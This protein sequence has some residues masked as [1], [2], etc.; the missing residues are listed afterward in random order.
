MPVVAS[1]QLLASA[2]KRESFVPVA[3]EHILNLPLEALTVKCPE[4]PISIPSGAIYT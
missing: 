3:L 1:V 2:I 4:V